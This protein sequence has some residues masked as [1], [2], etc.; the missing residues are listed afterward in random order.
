MDQSTATKMLAQFDRDP[1]LVEREKTHGSFEWNAYV[2]QK[3]K[4]IFRG[5][6]GYEHFSNAHKES[7]DMI[8]LKLSRLLQNPEHGEHW[9]DL[10]GYASLG[11]E[12]VDRAQARAKKQ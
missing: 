11:L 12:Q 1:L 4:A 7:L 6:P 8:A 2:S 5:C 3:I 10:A 9:L